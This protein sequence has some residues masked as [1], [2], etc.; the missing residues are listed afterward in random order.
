MKRL[1]TACLALLVSGALAGCIT[2]H[3]S[4]S[5]PER[6][7]VR[8][9]RVEKVVVDE[10]SADESRIFIRSVRIAATDVPAIADFY[11]KA[12]GMREIRRLEFPNLLEIIMNSGDSV[13]EAAANPHAPLVIMTRPEGHAVGTMAAVILSVPDM[14]A[15]IASVEAAGG[16][17]FRPA[18]S[19]ADGTVFAF[20]KD[21]EGNQVEL[22]L[23]R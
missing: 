14:E 18:Q 11:A 19:L 12:F 1:R 16:T 6:R 17:L 23:A 7:E 22:L 20:V 10:V 5:E 4:V 8:I 3:E 21:P 2:V 15:A 9:E 13:A